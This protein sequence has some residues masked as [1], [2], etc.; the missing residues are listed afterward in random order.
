[1]VKLVRVIRSIKSNEVDHKY[2]LIT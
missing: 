2:N 1:M